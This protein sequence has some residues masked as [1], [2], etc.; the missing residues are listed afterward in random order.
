LWFPNQEKQIMPTNPLNDALAALKD[1]IT[2]AE[3]TGRT[4]EEATQTALSKEMGHQILDVMQDDHFKSLSPA[5][6]LTVLAG[7]LGCT[8]NTYRL[9]G[10]LSGALV[11]AEVCQIIVEIATEK[12]N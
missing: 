8:I 2:R 1:S 4:D 6:K 11:A 5:V 3:K 7:V 10:P 12:D 9:A